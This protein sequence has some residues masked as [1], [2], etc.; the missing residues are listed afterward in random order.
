MKKG[1]VVQNPFV[2]ENHPCRKIIYIRTSGDFAETI[3]F[4]LETHKYYKS[5]FKDFPI[6]GTIE[7][8]F[9]DN[10]ETK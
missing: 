6:L 9:I 7:L 4:D 1:T 10:K 3:N 2:N 8:N 5:D